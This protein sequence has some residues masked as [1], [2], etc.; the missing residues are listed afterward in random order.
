VS[1][2]DY[3]TAFYGTAQGSVVGPNATV[4][5]IFQ[6]GEKRIVQIFGLLGSI[7]E[8][9]MQAGVWKQLHKEFQEISEH[10]VWVRGATADDDFSK[11]LGA[12]DQIW[13]YCHDKIQYFGDFGRLPDM[14]A[15]R[16][17]M[18]ECEKNAWM[19]HLQEYALDLE[20]IINRC[21]TPD[22]LKANLR[23][24]SAALQRLERLGGRLLSFLDARLQR[25]I[26]EL[27]QAIIHARRD[28][29]ETP[30]SMPSEVTS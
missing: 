27:E 22:D 2:P 4:T 9:R 17:F 11:A 10:L 26:K 12:L 15:K 24:F 3:E 16:E 23:E 28:L 21:E 7:D 6:N 19:K 1:T 25:V 18:A 30:S 8:N 20:V 13:P 14:A 29:T 5:M